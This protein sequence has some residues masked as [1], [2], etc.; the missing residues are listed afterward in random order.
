MWPATMKQGMSFVLFFSP[1][2]MELLVSFIWNQNQVDI[3]YNS[4]YRASQFEIMSLL[5]R[6][7]ILIKLPLKFP[8]NINAEHSINYTIYGQKDLECLLSGENILK[9]GDQHPFISNSIDASVFAPC[10]LLCPYLKRGSC[11]FFPGWP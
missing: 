10:H 9:N 3:I 1:W 8:L 6:S 7:A 5:C 4:S 11:D 2:Q